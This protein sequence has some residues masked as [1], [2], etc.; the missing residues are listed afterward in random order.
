MCLTNFSHLNQ[1]IFNPLYRFPSSLSIAQNY[2]FPTVSDRYRT[3]INRKALCA[4]LMN[5]FLLFFHQ[6]NAS[7]LDSTSIHRFWSCEQWRH[8]IVRFLFAYHPIAVFFCIGCSAMVINCR[9]LISMKRFYNQR[10]KLKALY[11]WSIFQ[12]AI[13]A[14][15]QSHDNHTSQ[16]SKSRKPAGWHVGCEIC[17]GNFLHTVP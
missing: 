17:F 13:I 5:M 4:Q 10:G 16:L 15:L 11:A 7:R 1:F 2:G 14:F 9:K 8:C 3:T 6:H 12:H